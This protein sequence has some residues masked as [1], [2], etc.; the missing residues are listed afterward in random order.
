M[1]TVEIRQ[2][3]LTA[4]SA[5]ADKKAFELTLL[6][7][8]GMTPLTD[9]FLIC[10]GGSARQVNAIA[11][12]VMR[13]LRKQGTHPRQVEGEGGTGWILIDYGDFVLHVFSEEKRAYYA[14]ES[15]WGDAP[16]IEPDDVVEG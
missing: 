9:G 16:R 2:R 15:L 4:A 14:L 3:M 1:L 11:D 8:S 7:V 10:S 12:A 6:D 13:E 5:A